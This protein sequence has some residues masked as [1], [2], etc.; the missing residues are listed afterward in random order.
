MTEI[1]PFSRPVRADSIPKDGLQ[2]AIEAS[3]TERDALAKLTGLEAVRRLA[4]KFTLSRGGRGAI[5]VRGEVHAEVT[6]TCVVSL[7]P[8]DV[9]LEESVDLR[10]AP[11]A[12]ESPPRRRSSSP[13]EAAEPLPGIEEDA[14]DP[15][16]DGK[17][18]LGAL[19]VEF[20]VLG[21]DPYPRKPGVDF[22]EPRPE[23]DPTKTS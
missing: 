5:G 22:A 8:F 13:P 10:F 4:A 21:L 3:E 9:T 20:M 7:E 1:G 18:D 23:N 16:V 17:I 12:G 2:Q 14:P 19:A 15:I 6:Q 11:P